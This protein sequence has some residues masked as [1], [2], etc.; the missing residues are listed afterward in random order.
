MDLLIKNY[1]MLFGPEELLQECEKK[2][3]LFEFEEF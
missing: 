1:N 2:P 3:N